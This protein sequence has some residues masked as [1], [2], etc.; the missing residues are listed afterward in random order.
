MGRSKNMQGEIVHSLKREI[1]TGKYKEGERLPSATALAK[2]FGVGLSVVREAISVLKAYGFIKVKRGRKGGVVVSDQALEIVT[3]RLMER[4]LMGEVAFEQTAKLRLLLE[5]DACRTG[6]AT[7]DEST[8]KRLREV[9]E[10]MLTAENFEEHS[11]LNME[12]HTTVGTMGG[13][14]L[15]G[16]FLKLL[17][18][19]TG[20]AAQLMSPDFREMHSEDEHQPIIEAI[21]DRDTERACRFL[22]A[23]IEGSNERVGKLEK[24]F[25][26]R[27]IRDSFSSL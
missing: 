12:F 3:D 25:F 22:R 6:T 2:K 23:H 21:A 4:L 10:R 15:Q 26:S 1:M 8:I 27:A 11:K 7:V 13:N 9:N 18:H 20:R 19:F 24:E 14:K 16:I 17:L 5:I